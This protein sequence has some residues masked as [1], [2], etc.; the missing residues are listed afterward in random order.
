VKIRKNIPLQQG[1]VVLYPVSSIPEGCKKVDPK[2]GRIVIAEGEAT[3][4]A[5][6]I[7]ASIG[8]MFVNEATKQTFIETSAPTEIDH[9][10]HE[11]ITVPPGKFRVHRVKEYDHFAEEA[12]Q[13]KD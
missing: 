7:L 10:E 2:L 13:V 11:K 12:R 3:G 5:H 1:D 8:T 9:Q 6:T 4:H